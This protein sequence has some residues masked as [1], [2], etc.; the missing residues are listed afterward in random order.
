M[1]TAPAT[2]ANPPGAPASIPELV[3]GYLDQILAALLELGKATESPGGSGSVADAGSV[4]GP[5]AGTTLVSVPA[6]GGG[7]YRIVAK[8]LK[9]AAGVGGNTNARLWAGGGP[10]SELLTLTSS[11]DHE[12]PDVLLRPGEEVSVRVIAADAGI[13]YSAFLTLTRVA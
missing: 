9:S 8:T 4:T 3:L 2:P 11:E 5:A 12:F 7:R 10:L 6:P 13:D 1:A